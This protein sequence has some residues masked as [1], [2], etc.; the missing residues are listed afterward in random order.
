MTSPAAE[1]GE[2]SGLGDPAELDWW[3]D[4][5]PTASHPRAVIAR[6]WDPGW[7]RVITCI[8]EAGHAAV[9]EHLGVRVTAVVISRD[10]TSGA[11]RCDTTGGTSAV[12]AV[13][14]VGATRRFCQESAGGEVDYRIAGDALAGTGQT[15]AWAEQRAVAVIHE[16]RHALLVLARQLHRHGR[17]G[18]RP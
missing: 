16:C 6:G 8:H 13:A 15:V 3:L 9:A 5:A 4:P 14:G 10:G 11:T 17:C 12:I 1:L 7:Q 2:R 18:S